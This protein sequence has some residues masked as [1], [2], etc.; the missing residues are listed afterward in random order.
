MSMVEM[1]LRIPAEHVQ[2]IFG[3]FDQY[4]KKIERAYQV[5]VLNRDGEIKILGS[6]T[7]SVPR[8]YWKACM[9]FPQEAHRSQSRM[10][11]IRLHY[12]WKKKNRRWW[13][14]TA[15]VFAIR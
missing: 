15:T 10:S 7:R 13:R 8:R 3:Q 6:P 1:S 11:T 5:T 9:S 4:V 14:S 12:L 2:N